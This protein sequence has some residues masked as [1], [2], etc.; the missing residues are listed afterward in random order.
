MQSKNYQLRPSKRGRGHRV[1]V[2]YYDTRTGKQRWVSRKLTKHLDGASIEVIEAWVLNWKQD[3]GIERD[4]I[5]KVSLKDSDLLAQLFAG[6]QSHRQALREI[7]DI[8]I[9]RER[10]RF[11]RFAFNYFITKHNQK[12]PHLW[13]QYVP[14]YYEYLRGL[15]LDV[16]TIKTLLWDIERFGK[17]LVF[18]R[19]M[20]HPYAVMIPRRSNRKITPLKRHITPEAIL[21]ARF[22]RTRNRRDKAGRF[23]HRLAVLLGYFATLAPSELFALERKDFLT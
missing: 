8:T 15:E 14:A 17:Y 11:E 3:H 1:F 18:V 5:A 6:Y 4:K 21:G 7:A 10:D 23:N 19:Y 20:D 2:Y 9:K 16:N 13:H 12:R 22:P